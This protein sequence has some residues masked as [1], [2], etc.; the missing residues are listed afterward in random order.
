[1]VWGAAK[2]YG[3]DM[4]IQILDKILV[5]Q[6]A[7]GEVVERPASVVKELVENS[8]DAGATEITVIISQGGQSKIEIIDNG[9]GMSQADALVAIERFG[10]S[11]IREVND[12]DN[13]TTHGFR[14]EALPAIAS[15]SKFKLSTCE[16]DDPSGLGTELEI[17]GGKVT[18]ITQKPLERGTRI[19]VQQLFFN[20]PARRKFLRSEKTEQASIKL[21][22]EDLAVA[23]PK[24]KLKFIADGKELLN[25]NSLEAQNNLFAARVRQLGFKE[26]EYFLIDSSSLPKQN[27]VK[28][29]GVL[30]EPVKAVANSAKLRL[31]VNG[32]SVRDKVIFKAVKDGYA[33]LI[34][35]NRYP[36]G[37]IKLTVLPQDVDVNV[38]P[39]K[40]EVRFR[41]P[42]L[43]Y[44]TVSQVINKTLS[45]KQP[46]YYNNNQV[47]NGFT[48][49][50]PSSYNSY[51]G[52]Q[53]NS[54]KIIFMPAV[55]PPQP[56]QQPAN[57][58]IAM[59]SVIG[60]IA[61]KLQD[62][63]EDVADLL[64]KSLIEREI[65]TDDTTF[66]SHFAN[67]FQASETTL[68]TSFRS[69]RSL[70]Y[71]GQVLGC[72]LLLESPDS[73]VV[74]D[75]HAAHERVTYFK[76]REQLEKQ[77]VQVQQLLIPET[78]ELTEEECENYKHS[79]EILHKLGLVTHLQN[80]TLTVQ[81]VPTILEKFLI[82]ELFKDLL[83]LPVWQ[84][85]N[86][87]LERYI[88]EVI[89]RIACHAAVR[90]GQI[91]RQE[92][93]TGL[94]ELVDQV[95]KSAFC[96]HGR[97]IAKVFKRR[98]LEALFGRIL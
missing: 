75:M 25:L 77:A 51:Y 30:C 89:A 50:A 42:E 2:F 86:D 28:I 9:S 5:N 12:L 14:G 45:S 31:I 74:L 94:L 73:L 90:S 76:L 29:E 70:R 52:K 19:E 79:K 85:W 7:A 18:D 71:V 47:E 98:E 35:N 3:E 58:E 6:I 91:L 95:E 4:K 80:T 63:E 15:V 34:S 84:D 87:Y 49:S 43:I 96:P 16:Q 59:A 17:I 48:N 88:D 83:S 26:K 33:N 27:F 92:E 61:V 72:F 38:H 55:S 22:L 68:S 21:L 36:D 44:C 40:T 60:N 62:Q 97:P 23:Y 82:S 93:V 67:Q 41:T 1:M 66:F 57:A 81:A 69:Y 8:I 10:T 78:L 24:L 13:I 56:A 11:K 65:T 46:E 53:D 20:V 64:E 39:Q 54:E 37:I 32:R